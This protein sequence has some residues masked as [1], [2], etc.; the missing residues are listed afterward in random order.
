MHM[1]SRFTY[2]NRGSAACDVS[3][4]LVLRKRQLEVRRKVALPVF[5]LVAERRNSAEG[6][7]M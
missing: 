2:Q 4:W 6:D 3:A 1:E 5:Q 7:V